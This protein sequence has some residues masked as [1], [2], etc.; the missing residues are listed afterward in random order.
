[1]KRIGLY[2]CTLNILPG[3]SI[4]EFCWGDL[5]IPA[6]EIKAFQN[7]C[8]FWEIRD[9][10]DS[11]TL[12]EWVFKMLKKPQNRKRLSKYEKGNVSGA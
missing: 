8:I 7:N 3:K 12:N 10:P 1:M 6:N 11:P 4:I 9:K 5:E 2:I